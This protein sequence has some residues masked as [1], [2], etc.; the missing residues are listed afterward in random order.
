MINGT[1]FMALIFLFGILANVSFAKFNMDNIYG[2]MNEIDLKAVVKQCEDDL[3]YKTVNNQ[4][5][6]A[7]GI[8]YHN[9]AALKARNASNNAVKYLEEAKASNPDDFVILAYL[10]S[11]TTMVAR[12]SWNFFAKLSEANKGINLIDKA[13]ASAPTNMIVRVV[14]ARNCLE[15]PAFLNRKALAKQDFIMVQE[16]LVKTPSGLDKNTKYEVFKQLANIYKS[17]KNIELSE[18][19]SK[20]AEDCLIK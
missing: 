2:L 10:G 12:D 14:R 9:L 6:K 5:L 1:R 3:K 18:V 13:V 16:L 11:A 8:A 7:L 19:Y 4:T 17:E 15:L 20:K